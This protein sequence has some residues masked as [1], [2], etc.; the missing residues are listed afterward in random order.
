MTE[1]GN[2]ES[3]RTRG[4]MTMQLWEGISTQSARSNVRG[5]LLYVEAVAGSV[6]NQ[7]HHGVEG[8]DAKAIVSAQ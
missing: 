2:E 8:L 3:A 1:E 6:N 5:S 7:S 4:V